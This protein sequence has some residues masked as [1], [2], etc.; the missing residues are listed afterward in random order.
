MCV[1]KQGDAAVESQGIK[2]PQA[3]LMYQ[4][5]NH[6]QAQLMDFL[7]A[8]SLPFGNP[9][10]SGKWSLVQ[11]KGTHQPFARLKVLVPTNLFQRTL[12]IRLLMKPRWTL[13]PA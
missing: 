13:L 12:L 10:L 1:G 3:Y 5:H 8:Y 11:S 2:K 7:G 9:V 6:L 4:T